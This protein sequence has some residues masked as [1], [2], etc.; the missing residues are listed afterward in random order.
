MFVK[1]S[2]LEIH[3]AGL[4][5]SAWQGA[6]LQEVL[7]DG[8]KRPEGGSEPRSLRLGLFHE[9]RVKWLVFDYDDSAPLI[10]PF[11]GGKPPEPQKIR[12][13]MEL[14]LRSAFVGRR[15]TGVTLGKFVREPQLELEFGEGYV[16]K[17]LIVPK[18][19]NLWAVAGEKQIS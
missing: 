4:E 12:R 1:M 2:I 8:R 11:S 19:R 7:V 5:V 3:E 18:F 10:L 15:L 16:L 17:F 13:P 6:Q 9:G 14:F